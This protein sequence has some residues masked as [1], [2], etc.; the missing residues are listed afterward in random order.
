MRKKHFLIYLIILVGIAVTVAC[1]LPGLKKEQSAGEPSKTTNTQELVVEE[2]VSTEIVTE[3][4]TLTAGISEVE[5]EP[6]ESPQNSGQISYL[7]EG[8]LW[9]YQVDSGEMIQLTSF[10]VNDEVFTSYPRARFSPDGRYLAFNLGGEPWIW[11]FE[12]DLI[13]DM[14]AYRHF[15]AWTDDAQKF[16]AINGDL[17]CPPIEDLD[18]QELMNFDIVQL[19]VNDLDNPSLIANVSGGLRFVSAITQNSEWASINSC[20]CCSECGP[21]YLWHLPTLN[22]V[23]PPVGIEAGNFDFSPDS[24]EMVF[25]PQQMYG[26]VE[27]ELNKSDTNYSDVTKLFGQSNAVPINARWSPN[28][29]WIAFT[30]IYLDD[31][32]TETD[33]CVHLIKPDGSQET[34]VAC[35]FSDL[36]TWSPDGSQLLYSQNNGTLEEYFIYHI[37]TGAKISIPI[38]VDPYQQGYI[39]WGWLP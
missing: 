17:E 38:Q 21:A 30:S 12:S 9:L 18:D 8:N 5:A 37:S 15:F 36:K 24:Q 26:Y 3:A 27:A 33:Q 28:G 2:E 23:T 7:H 35:Q 10:N 1:A 6:T 31:D 20:G 14:G 11:D 22:M 29:A 13:S 34:E 25:W 32:F 19:D 4:P 39:D 16:Y